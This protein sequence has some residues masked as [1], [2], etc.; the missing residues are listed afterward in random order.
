MHGSFEV[1]DIFHIEGRGTVLIGTLREGVLKKGMHTT[2]HGDVGE[3]VKID[4]KNDILTPA[5]G[6]VSIMVSGIKKDSFSAGMTVD[7]FDTSDQYLV[8]RRYEHEISRQ[9]YT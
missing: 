4:A 7:F 2:L 6:D 5:S 3:V 8:S 1:K 9:R